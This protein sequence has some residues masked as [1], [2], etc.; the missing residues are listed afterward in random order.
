MNTRQ[1][2]GL[3]QLL[4]LAAL[5]HVLGAQTSVTLSASPNPAK[6]GVPVV[7][8][9]TV[10]PSAAT[11][12]ITFYD[13]VNML[14]SKP[15]SSGTATLPEVLLPAGNRKLQAYYGGDAS[16]ASARSNVISQTVNAQPSGNFIGSPLVLV[17]G[18]VVAVADFNG[19]GKP[20]IAYTNGTTGTL[21]ILLGDGAGNFQPAFTWTPNLIDAATVG[22]FNGDGIPDLA[23]AAHSPASLVILLGNGD[24]T[25]QTGAS[26][27][28]PNFNYAML[29][30]DFNGDG[31]ADLAIANVSNGVSVF[32]GK[33]DGT[34]QAGAV[35]LSNP[36]IGNGFH[37]ADSIVA[38]DFNGDGKVDLA[39]MNAGTGVIGILL[40]AGD[41]TF[42]SAAVVT[43][44][45]L[46][47]A[48]FNFTLA[49]GDFNG[50]GKADLVTSN[51]D[52]LLGNGDGTFQKAVT[53]PAGSSQAGYSLGVAV[54]DFNGDGKIDFAIDNYFD[55]NAGILLG[56]G[57]GTFQP[58]V[59][60]SV[61]SPD[62]P[63]VSDFNGDGKTDLLVMSGN[64][65]QVLY[66]SNLAVIA[67]GGTPQ[68]ALIT[69]PF[70][71]PLQVAV[72]DGANPVVGVS[73]AFTVP[74]S[75]PS[76][77]LSS[78]S[79]VTDANG[80]ARVTATANSVAGRYS[81]TA[82]NALSAQ[83][84]LTNL[85][86]TA[87]VMTP[88]PATESTLIGT[89][90]AKPLQ[91]TVTDS[92]GLPASGV[93]VTFT[94]PASAASAVVNGSASGT[95]TAVTD[96]T[97]VASVAV[98]ANSI[99]GSY[100][101]TATAGSLSATF[102]LT[103]L[104]VTGISSSPTA[105]Q[106][107]LL[108]T[109]FAKPLTVAL[110]YGAGL[111]APGI[112]VTFTA[113][114]SGAS[115]SLTATTVVTDSNGLASV[116]A[117][118]NGTPGS[119]TVTASAQGL[120]TTFSLTNLQLVPVTV[121]LTTS[122]NPST[123]GAPV[124][125]TASVPNSSGTG[126]VTFYDG[127]TMLGIATASSGVASFSTPALSA[128]SHKLTAYYRDQPNA[129]IGTSSAVTQTVKASAGGAFT[130][131]SPFGANLSPVAAAMGDFNGD[132]KV[133][134]ALALTGGNVAVLLSKGDGTFQPPVN[135]T[136]G[137]GT[138]AS[139]LAADFNGDGKTDLIVGGSGVGE[140]LFG[141]GDGTFRATGS[142]AGGGAGAS[143][144]A[145]GDFNGDGREDIMYQTTTT[146]FLPQPEDTLRPR[147]LQPH[148]GSPVTI[149][150]LSLQLGNGDG[151][152][153]SPVG[154]GQ[155][156][157]ASTV[158]ADFNG[159]GKADLASAAYPTYVLLGNGAG[160]FSSSL[161]VNALTSYIL[162]ST[163]L[164]AGDFDGDGKVDLAL[165]AVFL[166]QSA[167]TSLAAVTFILLGNGDGTFQT[168]VIYPFGAAAASGDFNGDGITDLVL[169]DTAGNTSG[170]SLGRGDGT[171]QQVT[172]V[173]AGQPLAVMDFNGDGKADL[174]T[175][176]PSNGTLTILLGTTA[177]G[178]PGPPASITATAGTPQSS[179]L[180][181][182]FPN[183]L[184]VT[185]TDSNGRPVVGAIVTFT[186]PAANA[187]A[188]LSSG[189]ALT[190]ASGVASVNAT[191]NTFGGSY[192]VTASV[193]ALTAQ[194]S[195]TNL[196]AANT[197]L[198]LSRPA[199]QSSTFPGFFPHS[200][201]EA[202]DGDTDG[203]FFDNSV[204]STNLDANP[205]WEVDLG[206]S[207]SVASVTIFNRTD[208]CGSRLSD[209]WIFISDTPFLVSDTSATLSSR[210]GTFSS[211]QTTAPNPTGTIATPGAQ[212]RYVRVQLTSA[213][214]LSLAEVQVFGA[215]GS[216][217]PAN[218]AL[219]QPALQSSTFP[220][221]T[222]GAG[223]AV[224]GVTD[225]NFGDGS[226][227]ATNAD[228]NAWWQ[229][230]LGGV[231]A[232]S[233]VVIWNRTD[234]CQSRLGD[235]WVFVS[236]TPFLTGDT[237]ATLQNRAGTF[238][239]HQ[240][241][242]PNPSTT[243]LVGAQ[244]RYV[245]VQLTGTDY[246]SLAEV[247]V[248][249]TGLV[250]P[251][252]LSVGK[253]AS[254]S[255]T[256]PGYATAGAASAVDGNTDGKFPDGSVTA[257]NADPNA[258][259]Q[260]DLG[261]SAAVSTV[262]IWNRTDCCA[263]RLGDFWV[264]VSDSPFAPT[265]TPLSL[266]STLGVYAYHQ[267]GV[268]NPVVTI[269]VSAQGRYVR[270]QLTGTDYLSLAEVEVFGTGGAP[271]PPD[272]A[273]GMPATQSSTLP[274]YPS[275]VAGSAVDGN[276]DGNFFDYSV[277]ATNLELDPWWEVDL[278]SSMAIGSIVVWNRTDQ[279]CIGD[280]ADYWVFVSNTPF[281]P[282]DTVTSLQSRAGTVGFQQ[283]TYPSPNTAIS[284][285][286]QGRYVRVQLNETN[287][288]TLAE[289]QVFGQ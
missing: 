138:I 226:V 268:P 12:H 102:S 156:A 221:F 48:G 225:G 121:T 81:V 25:F 110:T 26:Y 122:P 45:S 244:G 115:A 199:T 65:M 230:D 35:Y 5:P 68:S 109:Y 54:G 147:G 131:L 127:V 274:G 104:P 251:V 189:N 178:A 158:V 170:L 74:S 77:T 119:Y 154:L 18:S 167:S 165:G 51:A 129:T 181:T 210:A 242:A 216:P 193:G 63:F 124:S 250:T 135:Y 234:C 222:A 79:A 190:N 188:S 191:A 91:V 55:N 233:S 149:P 162:T 11:G 248:F 212:G 2:P 143:G 278:G 174:L 257:T 211:H 228:P 171:F 236:N 99:T 132:G 13:G 207:A 150:L 146:K 168:P 266:S 179:P 271:S 88:S 284:V 201:A 87:A 213:G 19:D 136:T 66:G 192:T 223:A 198:A 15:I 112:A 272:L 232:V 37:Q 144:V 27:S 36:Q 116:S 254:Q 237:P 277:S 58:V 275:A 52:V 186:A 182:A 151:T 287:Y 86:A 218:L 273:L 114:A 105:P 133:D 96:A 28:L 260:V 16:H 280:L 157:L 76:A 285:G 259:W 177:T 155:L 98:A 95:A 123:L 134:V 200:A 206:G 262:V 194:F 219:G 140:I 61:A 21:M 69:R 75:G 90:F 243:I 47:T 247:Q 20:D 43:A 256:L 113:P 261:G 117:A 4:I 176:N 160:G 94:A 153:G 31:K 82:T 269:P 60:H 59:T 202:V 23:V 205:W 130:A 32:L 161:P 215:F 9:A 289:V 125:L 163:V 41:G 128:G 279:C 145:V 164:V 17:T 62:F 84:A 56:N 240:T 195:L 184:Q 241:S 10:T 197:N 7:L 57:D 73:V 111:P 6:L 252:N 106:S 282:T 22:D 238:S 72:M 217:V 3:L 118:A 263:S 107:T 283:L 8:T 246:L 245:R 183:P 264:F 92:S 270:V 42:Q 175:A 185:V 204:S 166:P 229:V 265:D 253:S 255:S 89:F 53:Y 24:G 39:A 172:A 83:F 14:G 38:A 173:S 71:I 152:F 137:S 258:W 85:A 30:A 267:V 67:T 208:C 220:G 126:V 29:T 120:S 70:P 141:N 78:N 209:Y 44:N 1:L 180:S 49:T 286:A 276:T 227:T 249:G 108:G 224:D 64:S 93:T 101:V 187:S 80:V 239:S 159:D 169:T 100:Q 139:I 50:D 214:Y 235:Y 288:L 46:G 103:N 281:L 33:G 148:E 34:F 231:A 40:G 97:G 203:N 196:V 142:Y